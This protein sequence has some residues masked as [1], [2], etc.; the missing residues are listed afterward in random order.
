[1][2]Y[3]EVLNYMYSQLP[4]FHH[5]GK[6]AYK[7]NLDT[8]VNID[9]YFNHPHNN[10]RTIHVAGTNGKGSVSH[11]LAATLQ[12]AGYKTGLFTSPHLKDFRERILVNG[13]MIAETEITD[14]IF[15][16]KKYFDE[17]KPSFF[18][19]ISAMAFYYF[20]K[21]HVD[22]AVIE[23]GM[24]GRLD[25]TNV[26]TPIL[27]VI[28]NIGLDHTEFLGKTPDKIAAEK[29]GIIKKSVPV[30]IGEY[31]PD[32]WPVFL[33]F[34]ERL[35]A[36]MVLAEHF[37]KADTL[38]SSDTKQVFN[39]TFNDQPAYENL[40]LDFTG[41]YQRKNI[42]TVLTAIDQLQKI[43]LAIPKDAVYKALNNVATIAQLQ[44]RWQTI[45]HN[46]L[47]I[48]DTGH[49]Y[50]GLAWVTQQIKTMSYKKL[51][52]VIGFVK[53]K[54]ISSMLKILPA[55]AAYYFTNAN[56]PRAL[57]ARE[58]QKKAVEFGLYGDSYQS[59]KAALDAAKS[60]ASENDLIFVGGSTFVVAEVI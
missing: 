13:A 54:D 48:C 12:T 41:F 59:V 8:S 51:H 40:K 58:L 7:A 33:Q 35:N 15:H 10:Y 4:M 37:C 5:I 34:S 1:M 55:D 14:F 50:D 17:V 2:T 22:V 28:T 16:H 11:M 20:A 24:G 25:S 42:C 26:I 36:P 21:V 23:V 57:N 29:A 31:H 27:S 52:I 47:I 49:N 39:I 45:G 30:V 44:G 43:G 18:E 56:I 19:M 46:P 9:K 60:K 6:S 32:T 53:D 3:K 38:P